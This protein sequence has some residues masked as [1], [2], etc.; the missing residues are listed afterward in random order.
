MTAA[1]KKI[2]ILKKGTL[3]ISTAMTVKEAKNLLIKLFGYNALHSQNDRSFLYNDL[4]TISLTME[5]RITRNNIHCQFDT[6]NCH[7][8]S[9]TCPFDKKQIKILTAQFKAIEIHYQTQ[10]ILVLTRI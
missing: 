3:I 10:P 1:T 7:N 9:R 4:C 5:A 6:S 2:F 8:N